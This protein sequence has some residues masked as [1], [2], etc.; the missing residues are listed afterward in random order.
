LRSLV[1]KYFF[2]QPQVD[3]KILEKMLF[4]NQKQVSRYGNKPTQ[5]KSKG[6]GEKNAR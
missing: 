3:V 1:A 4:F 5:F 2:E 6:L